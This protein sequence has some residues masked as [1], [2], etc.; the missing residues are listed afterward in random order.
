MT[1]TYLQPYFLVD[2]TGVIVYF[3]SLT[4]W[5]KV[6]YILWLNAD[7][8]NVNQGEKIIVPCHVVLWYVP[9]DMKF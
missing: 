5:D 4:C 2:S 3:N 1:V 8:I 7:G 9:Q 6:K